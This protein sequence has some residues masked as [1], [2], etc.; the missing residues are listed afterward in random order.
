MDF[1]S[2][3]ANTFLSLFPIINPVGMAPVFMAMTSSFSA[4]VRHRMA[5][6]VSFYSFML[7]VGSLLGG[8]AILHFF[9]LSIGIIRIAGGLIVF[10][11]AWDMLNAGPKLSTDETHESLEKAQEM[12][13]FPLTMPITVGA[14]CIAISIAISS[15]L[16]NFL[17][18]GAL[19][20]YLAAIAAMLA[21]ALCIFICYRYSDWLCSKLG[22]VGTNVVTKLSAFILLAVGVEIVWDGIRLLLHLTI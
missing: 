12:A 20:S 5:V 7:L 13:F 6:K 10:H 3:F 8:S 14:G 9:G 4:E 17:F 11:S 18:H 15:Q 22:K 16:D 1:W 2:S 21:L 19:M